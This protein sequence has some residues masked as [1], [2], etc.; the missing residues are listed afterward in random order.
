MPDL[1]WADVKL[2]IDVHGLT[3]RLVDSQWCLVDKDTGEAPRSLPPKLKDL[4]FVPCR[5]PTGSPGRGYPE[6]YNLQ[7]KSSMSDVDYHIQ[8][9]DLKIICQRTHAIDMTMTITKQVKGATD[10]VFGQ[11]LKVH[12]EFEAWR[13]YGFWNIQAGIQ[14][15]LHTLAWEMKKKL[16][17]PANLVKSLHYGGGRDKANWGP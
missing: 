12:P 2:A 4:A 14:L 1:K 7:E 17:A 16:K 6:G 9:A 11:F 13:K 15:I 10:F 5:K 8:Q 3:L